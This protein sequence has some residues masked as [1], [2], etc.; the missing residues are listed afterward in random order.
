MFCIASPSI[1]RGTPFSDI[2]VSKY[3]LQSPFQPIQTY[4]PTPLIKGAGEG[5]WGTNYGPPPFPEKSLL[6]WACIE[7]S[8]QRV[9][10][11]QPSSYD[12]EQTGGTSTNPRAFNLLISPW[13]LFRPR[14]LSIKQKIMACM[15][16]FYVTYLTYLFYARRPR[17]LGS[18]M[19]VSHREK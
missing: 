15:D 2:T 14:I 1:S 5:L 11:I 13:I 16:G 18:K 10:N 8:N 17:F 3:L 19:E 6:F 9:K 4:Q 7:T 12:T